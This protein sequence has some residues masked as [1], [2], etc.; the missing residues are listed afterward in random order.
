MATPT[1]TFQLTMC[2]I[3]QLLPHFLVIQEAP[4]AAYA[5]STTGLKHTTIWAKTL[6]TMHRFL[7]QVAKSVQPMQTAEASFA[8]RS[9]RRAT[10]RRVLTEAP[11]TLMT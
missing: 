2:L 1:L 9:P 7:K 3:S 6:Q 5:Q 4:Y 10:G 11:R 8:C